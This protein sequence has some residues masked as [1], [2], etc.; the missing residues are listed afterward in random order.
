M[1]TGQSPVSELPVAMGTVSTALSSATL[2]FFPAAASSA[3]TSSNGS[4][5]SPQQTVNF[6]PYFTR[7]SPFSTVNGAAIKRHGSTRSLV[8]AVV[9]S[10][11][12][13]AECSL[14]VASLKQG[15]SFAITPSLPK[16]SPDSLQYEPG[17]LGAI[18]DKTA[19]APGCGVD[20]AMAYLTRIITSKVYDVAV[21]SALELAPKLSQRLRLRMLLKREDLQPVFS[22]KLRGAYNMMANLSQEQLRRGVICS[23]AGNHA[24]G[25]ALAARKLKCHA[26]IAMPVTTP[27]IK[28]LIASSPAP[29]RS[30]PSPYG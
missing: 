12:A 11:K 3:V 6:P 20:S 7:F 28:V 25:V 8:L 10:D 13:P 17:F 2:P 29:F 23:S 27:D 9:Q 18:S 1:T 24:Q 4:L 14:D 26:V 15:A 30:R 5:V 21:E 19:P 16:V 22:F